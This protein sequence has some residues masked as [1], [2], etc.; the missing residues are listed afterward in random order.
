MVSFQ[1]TLTLFIL[2]ATLT[3]AQLFP[4][5]N[6]KTDLPILQDPTFNLRPAEIILQS[7]LRAYG[8]NINLD[9]DVD[10]KLDLLGLDL[11]KRG[12]RSRKERSLLGLNLNL[13]LGGPRKSDK[14]A[15]DLG[16][17]DATKLDVNAEGAGI[18]LAANVSGEDWGQA[19]NAR[20]ERGGSAVSPFLDM[21]HA[22]ISSGSH[23][24]QLEIPRRLYPSSQTLA[25]PTCSSTPR[26]AQ[27]AI[28]PTIPPLIPKALDHIDTSR[29]PGR[30]TT[31]TNQGLGATSA[32]TPS[33]LELLVSSV[34]PSLSRLLQ[35]SPEMAIRIRQLVGLWVC[36]LMI[37]RLCR[38]TN[39]IREQH[40]FKGWS[41]R[42]SWTRMY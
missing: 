30:W 36:R 18:N 35:S 7:Q 42:R 22:L 19:D 26:P 13:G 4:F 3:T 10:I 5:L 6:G 33:T 27:T 39:I 40:C 11:L 21:R 29:I 32:K 34:H 28:C 17:G 8:L 1:N 16:V 41:R 37:S 20:G 12:K 14:P 24:L 2:H 25:L 23:T 9:L 31:M 15:I 38:M